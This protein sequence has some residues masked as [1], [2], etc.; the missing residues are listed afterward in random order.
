MKIRD[1]TPDNI[2][3]K[4]VCDLT[5]D[6]VIC[7]DDNIEIRGYRDYTW[8]IHDHGEVLAIDNEE[9]IEHVEKL[10]LELSKKLER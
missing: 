3:G 7:L 5:L 6:T 9:D 8:C 10:C 2:L 4:Y 1:I